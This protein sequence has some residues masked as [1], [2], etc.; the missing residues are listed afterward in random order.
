MTDY[1][2]SYDDDE[3]QPAAGWRQWVDRNGES[4]ALSSEQAI[5][6][7]RRGGGERVVRDPGRRRIPIS[8][9]TWRE[10][11][12]AEAGPARPPTRRAGRYARH[13]A[14]AGGGGQRGGG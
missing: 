10:R 11:L 7:P 1:R 13:P 12:L 4:G 8:V 9:Q 2:A 3:V 14:R 5:R 6:R